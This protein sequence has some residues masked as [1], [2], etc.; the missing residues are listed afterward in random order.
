VK[1]GEVLVAIKGK[2]GELCDIVIYLYDLQCH[3]FGVKIW[4]IFK[5]FLEIAKFKQ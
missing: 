5:F 2:L 3:F 1:R 4:R